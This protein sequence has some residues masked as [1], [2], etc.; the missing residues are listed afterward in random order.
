MNEDKLGKFAECI[1]SRLESLGLCSCHDEA[2]G[3]AEAIA[4]PLPVGTPSEADLDNAKMSILEYFDV[5]SD[6]DAVALVC[7]AANGAWGE[8]VAHITDAIM[9]SRDGHGVPSDSSEGEDDA[10][11]NPDYEGGDGDD[12]ECIGEGECELCERRIKLTR[13][14]L[15]PKT[16]WPRMKKRLWNAA[17]LI[18]SLHS[19]ECSGNDSNCDSNRLEERRQDLQW[20][21]EKMLGNAHVHSVPRT[22][23]H[24]SIR[25]YLSQ[26]CSLCRQCHSAVHRIH[27]EWELATDYNTMYRLLESEE[28]IKFARWANKQHPGMYRT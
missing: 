5:L 8:N 6:D 27:T 26:V 10:K 24:D 21:L 1:A 2:S 16:T 11:S 28:V 15:I 25:A 9:N 18:E 22:I 13:H 23:T 20:K 17:P 7:V 3:V 14:H 19:L 4:A 12:G